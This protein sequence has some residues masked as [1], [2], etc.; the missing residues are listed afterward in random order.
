[1]ATRKIFEPKR[2]NRWI[3]ELPESNIESSLIQK[4]V[5]PKFDFSC[6]DNS[7]I[8]LSFLT[9][10]SFDD[11]EKILSWASNDSPKTIIVKLLNKSGNVIN[12]FICSDCKL[13]TLDFGTL[14][15]QSSEMFMIKVSFSF[16]DNSFG[17]Y[18]IDSE[19]NLKK[20][21]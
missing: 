5:L 16:I 7:I 14:D 21:F 4:V 12:Q 17:Y 20:L 15:Y 13:K 9:Q 1:M 8:E 19:T 18:G 3:C 6:L 10:E 11:E 2:S